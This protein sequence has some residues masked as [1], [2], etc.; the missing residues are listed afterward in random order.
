MYIY[1][2]K[3]KF[4]RKMHK[5]ECNTYVCT[6]TLHFVLKVVEHFFFLIQC[7]RLKWEKIDS[8]KLL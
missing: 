7:A 1:K 6:C 3:E 5:N 4:R 8:T 2:E